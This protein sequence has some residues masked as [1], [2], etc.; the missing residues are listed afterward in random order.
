MASKIRPLPSARPSSVEEDGE[1]PTHA[2]A[3]G[4]YT[5]PLSAQL[6]R[7]VWDRGCT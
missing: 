3:A 4:A 2:Y 6:V 1:K 7:F 5:R